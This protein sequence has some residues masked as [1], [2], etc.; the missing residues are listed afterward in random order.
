M[1]RMNLISCFLITSSTRWR[2]FSLRYGMESHNGRRTVSCG[3][4]TY[5]SFQYQAV[6][7][8]K[9]AAISTV[10]PVSAYNRFDVTCATNLEPRPM[11]RMDTCGRQ[12][13]RIANVS[14]CSKIVVVS[15][16]QQILHFSAI[17]RIKERIKLKLRLI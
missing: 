16:Q 11:N 14:C 6:M 9:F 10:I 12:N 4:Q 13:S 5:C 1:C 2:T 7:R 15:P 8:A 3:A 17:G